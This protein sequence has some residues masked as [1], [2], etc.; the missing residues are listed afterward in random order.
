MNKLFIVAAFLFAGAA[1]Q[2][3]EK[4][5][6]EADR[7]ADRVNDHT[8]D[9][10]EE[11]RE[12]T[13]VANDRVGELREEVADK[14]EDIRE[15]ARANARAI[16]EEAKDVG[17]EAHELSSAQ[18][19]FEH[20][21]TIRIATLRGVQSV[22]ASQ[23]M[24]LN[25]FATTPQAREKLQIFQMRLDEAGNQIQALQSVPATTWEQRHDDVNM[26][27]SRLEDSREDAWESVHD[28]DGLDRTSMR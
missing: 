16:G 17:E 11:S 10:R 19:D 23:T 21:R 25:S 9:L 5:A 15:E 14:T 13:E 4:T 26:A 6:R 1:C 8:R 7:Q 22:F 24:L 12:V 2:Q 28:A 18:Q 27:M 20:A 3:N